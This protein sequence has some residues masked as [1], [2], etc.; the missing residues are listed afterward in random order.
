MKVVKTLLI[1]CLLF[2]FATT[3]QAVTVD[4]YAYLENQT[5]HSGTRVLFERTVPS[6]LIDST[7]TSSEGYYTVDLEVGIYNVSFYHDGYFSSYKTELHDQEIF[8]ATTLQDVLLYELPMTTLRVPEHY[9][10]IG[11]AIEAASNGD[12]ILIADGVYSGPEN[13]NLSWENKKLVIKSEN[14]PENCIIDCEFI[15]AIGFFLS[16]HDSTD[17]IEGLTIKNVNN[18]DYGCIYCYNSSPIIKNSLLTQ[19][20]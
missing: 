15:K 18:N 10:T 1:V 20:T 14:G 4:G 2:D 13:R 8:D 11:S 6:E 17:I 12:T 9:P 16:Q 7:F 5:D 3:L 19:L